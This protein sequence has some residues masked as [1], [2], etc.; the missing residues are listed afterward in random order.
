MQTAAPFVGPFVEQTAQI[1]ISRQ[2]V[3]RIAPLAPQRPRPIRLRESGGPKCV[4]ASALAGLAIREKD[5]IDL[6]LR[7]G[8]QL[9]A[10]LEKGCPSVD[11][12]SGFYLKKS[13]DGRICADRDLLHSRAGG[14]CEIDRFRTLT[15]EVGK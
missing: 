5:A 6:V 2:T 3:V 1:S 15:P 10:K 13:A 11:F 12:Y 8:M 9:R 7:G 4:N 14:T